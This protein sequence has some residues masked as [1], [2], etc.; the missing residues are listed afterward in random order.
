MYFGIGVCAFLLFAHNPITPTLRVLTLPVKDKFNIILCIW[1]AWIRGLIVLI[2]DLIAPVVV[3]IALLFTK[4]EDEKLPWLFRF[5]DNDASINGD[6]RTD[7]ITNEWGGWDLKPVPLEKD[8]Q[9]AIDMCYWAKGH[10]PRSF[11]ARW[12]WL[13][14]R[15][16]ASKMSEMVGVHVDP[17]LPV[18]KYF[19]GDAHGAKNG[20][21]IAKQG[22]YY[23]LFETN[24]CGPIFFRF[25]Y[26]FKVPTLK[27]SPIAKPISIAFSF[28]KFK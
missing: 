6:V 28:Q 18:E 9:A 22:D 17:S 19:G 10:H 26:G 15:N 7:D 2:P 1:S 24:R 11:Y 27:I 16:R 3:P 13:G 5:W 21:V 8:S 25:Y 12:V 4:W 20:W 14:L 23:S